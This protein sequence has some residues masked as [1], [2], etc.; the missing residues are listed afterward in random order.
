MQEKST[1]RQRHSF[2]ETPMINQNAFENLSL[3]EQIN[4]DENRPFFIERSES[5]LNQVLA[6][7]IIDLEAQ[8]A[9]PYAFHLIN[10]NL[11]LHHDLFLHEN[12]D[13]DEGNLRNQIRGKQITSATSYQI[14]FKEF[15]YCSLQVTKVLMKKMI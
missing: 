14:T 9:S 2:C 3:D 1:P 4:N 6:S 8:R 12:D 5:G 15:V 10:E 11:E 7:D 13:E